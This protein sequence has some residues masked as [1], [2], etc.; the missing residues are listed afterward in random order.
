MVLREDKEVDE[1][2]AEI[3]YITSSNDDFKR[4]IAA[5]TNCASIIFQYKYEG[6]I[7]LLPLIRTLARTS[8]HYFCAARSLVHSALHAFH[9]NGITNAASAFALRFLCRIRRCF[10]MHKQQH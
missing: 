9:E 7:F 4:I 5:E 6:N 10:H 1:E 2:E 3:Q 8:F